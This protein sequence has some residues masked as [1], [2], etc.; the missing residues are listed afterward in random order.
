MKFEAN[1]A[2]QYY[3]EAMPLIGMVHRESRASLWAM[4][5]IYYRLL[6]RI[7]QKQYRVLDQRIRLTTPE[8]AWLVLQA[9]TRK[10]ARAF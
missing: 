8:K 4:I 1:R 9:S 6:G 3:N 5:Q 7:E 2:R 10:L